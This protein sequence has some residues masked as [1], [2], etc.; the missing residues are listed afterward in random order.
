MSAYVGLDVHKDWSFATV[1][2]QTGRVVVRR[3]LANEHVPSF[4]EEFNVEKVGLESSTYV[5]PLYRALVDRGFRVEV[6][7][8]KK[9][10]YI[11]EARIK[12]DRVDSKAIA[13]LV[14]L[15]ALPQSY[16]P[17]PDIAVLR[18]KVRRRAFLVRQRAKLMAKI[19]VVLAYEGL[20]PP[21]GL[22][23]F[24]RK[25]VD[26]LES[27]GL[28]PVNCY[29]RLIMA[30]NGE[31][32]RLSFDL[33]RMAGLDEDVRLLMTIPGV[34]YYTALLV[35]AETGDVNRFRSGEHYCSF[36]GI[37]PSTYS[38]GGVTRHG[39]ITREGNP[40]LRWAL[41]EAAMTHVKY[42]TSISRS[43]HRIAERRGRKVALVA[44]ARRLAL[45]CYSVLKNRRPYRP[46]PHGQALHNSS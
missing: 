30:F 13:E 11:A 27:L 24:T 5:V 19:R 1:L 16:M 23:L 35:K 46:F 36:I 3:K 6:G 33:R 34:G 18:E 29:L 2:D 45:C 15:D 25:G 42:D 44:T 12:S 9:T 7:H 37:V 17:P 4:L 43:Y 14:R 41:F 20:K 10:R 26:W 32:R 31:I 28:E 39:G 38:S 22:S 21:D 40:W 8:P